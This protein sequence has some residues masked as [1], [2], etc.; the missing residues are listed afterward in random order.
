MQVRWMRDRR[1][2]E[3]TCCGHVW[4]LMMSSL[5]PE[6]V[7]WVPT[8]PD[9]GAVGSRFPSGRRYDNFSIVRR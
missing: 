8:C 5:F 3:W 1:T 4:Q 6:R 7:E 2:K 9:C